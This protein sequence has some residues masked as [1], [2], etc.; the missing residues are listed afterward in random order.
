[1]LIFKLSKTIYENS[2]IVIDFSQ[3]IT[4]IQFRVYENSRKLTGLFTRT[5]I[6][7]WLIYENK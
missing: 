1:M 2:K 5:Y 7:R 4:I 3:N 6:M